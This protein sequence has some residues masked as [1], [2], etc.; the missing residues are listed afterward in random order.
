MINRQ[1][2]A[3]L[4][5]NF[6]LFVTGWELN[7][8]AG[9]LL[10]FALPLYVLLQTGDPALMGAVLAVSVL[11]Q[12]VLTPMGGVIADRF[13]KRRFLAGANFAV[14]AAVLIWLLTTGGLDVVLSATI[15]MLV[16]LGLEA[17]FSPVLE[18]VVPA[19]VP[20][21]QLVRANSVTFALGLASG[22]GAPALGGALLARWGLTVALGASV[23]LF[24]LAA[25]ITWFTSSPR[26]TQEASGPLLR[27]AV[28]D[29]RD[30]ARHVVSNDR[31]LRKVLVVDVVLAF[32]LA[33]LQLVVLPALLVDA[34]LSSGQ[35][36]WATGITMVGAAV[37]VTIMGALGA[38][39]TVRL[40]RPIVLLTA[41]A[42]AATG[43][44]FL[45][46]P[47]P[48]GSTLVLVGGLVVAFG[49]FA[50]FSVLQ[51]SYVGERAPEHLV[52]KIFALAMVLSA[53]GV[54][55]G[56]WVFG[57]LIT[58]FLDTPAVVLL[59]AAAIAAAVA[60]GASMSKHAPA[61][62]APQ[63]EVPA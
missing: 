35:I 28:T 26:A 31:G 36:G 39:A 15:L 11:P 21:D 5:R 42:T 57:E 50:A 4:S 41:V 2:R 49:L 60:A 54:A 1:P 40:V 51:W 61:S 46:N 7:Q 58:R 30:A 34:G 45:A 25:V 12:V 3:L 43:F 48:T 44:A 53:L 29:L 6:V 8:I 9:G 63:S 27:T 18:A 17:L 38:R 14:A 16:F 59:F 47:G 37:S 24:A 13:D 55:A 32:A 23:A 22:V 52:G 19:L 62:P 33:P 20:E 56:T 10:R